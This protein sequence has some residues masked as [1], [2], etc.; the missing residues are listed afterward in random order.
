[1]EADQLLILDRYVLQP[2]AAGALG[3]SNWRRSPWLVAE[4]RICFTRSEAKA[5]VNTLAL[6]RLR[7]ASQTVSSA[8]SL[9]GPFAKSQLANSRLRL[10]NN[11]ASDMGRSSG[12]AHNSR[13]LPTCFEIRRSFAPVPPVLLTGGG[14]CSICLGVFGG[15]QCTEFADTFGG[16]CGA[17]SG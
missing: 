14:R 15:K 1:M 13:T 3:P 7:R 10:R 17:A 12:P 5:P 11:F 9:F 6:A 2:I 16:V 8:M 4:P